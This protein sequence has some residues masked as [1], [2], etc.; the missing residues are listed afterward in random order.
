M[1][2]QQIDL[3]ELDVPPIPPIAKYSPNLFNLTLCGIHTDEGVVGLGETYGAPSVFSERA[4]SLTGRDPLALDPLAQP[5]P[6]ACALLDIAGQAG[7]IPLHRFFGQKVRDRV[8]V[9]YWSRPMEPHETAAEAAD[10]PCW[11]QMGGLCLG[12]ESRLLRAL[13]GDNPQCDASL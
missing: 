13:A 11:V 3:Y 12:V 4:A 1:K 8:P 5:D 9:S 6:F 7:G 10:V 2:I